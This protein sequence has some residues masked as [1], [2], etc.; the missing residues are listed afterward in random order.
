MPGFF[1]ELKRRN[2]HRA[3]AFYGGAA[4]LLVQIATQVFPFFH[5]ADGVVQA[6]VIGAFVIFPVVL[7]FAWVYEW[8]PQGIKLESEIDRSVSITQ[9]TG[10]AMD[11]WIIVVLS[12]AVLLLL[13][14]QFVLHRF[15]TGSGGD[16]PSIAV[17][18]MA[19][20]TGDP[21]NEYFSDGVSEELINSLSRLQGLKVI[22]RTSSFKFKGSKDDSKTI[23][24]A[25]QV[26]YLLEGSVRRSGEQVRIAV[27]LIKAA[28]G[29]SLWSQSFDREFKDIFAIQT[30]ISATVAKSL[31]VALLGDNAQT[32][33]TPL[34]SAPSNDNAAAYAAL[35]QGNFYRARSTADDFRKAIGFYEE[36]IALDPRYA[37]AY[38]AMAAAASS[39]TASFL[40]SDS[41][42]AEKRVLTEKAQTGVETALRL[43]PDL[44]E[45]HLVNGFLAENVM[46]L[47]KTRA[48]CAQAAELAP[49]N[50]RA[51]MCLGRIQAYL[52]QVQASVDS[53]RRALE[54]EPLGLGSRL[55]L[56]IM[57]TALGRYD[58]AT[59]V[60]RQAIELQ[61]RA[62]IVHR[63]LSIIQTLRGDNAAA[64]ATALQE[65]DPY[66]QTVTLAQSYGAAGLQPQADVQLKKLIDENGS[67]GASQI[68]QTYAARRE[69][70]LAFE[71]LE[72]ARASGDSG[73]LEMRYDPFLM[74]YKS[75]PR[76]LAFGRKIGVISL[77]EVP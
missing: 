41:D 59:A 35:L 5:I 1:S 14:N 66:W 2:V 25:L 37:L 18:P 73:I 46:D 75:D 6:I 17:L 52:G 60:V 51:V 30:E 50:P 7:V 69:P 45:A 12:L 19:N 65:T 40:V 74:R 39:L 8:T 68:A 62:A 28:D 4:W 15:V 21:G 49:S 36:A 63:Q 47:V 56:S 24:E 27:S 43:A 10:K 72:R 9:Q 32:I 77:D 13:L 54:L 31:K 44:A 38:A 57:L 64:I 22:G 3:A 76:Y 29:S 11:R 70:D 34:P 61:P 16:Q 33:N 58:E 67:D 23:A 48:E 53:N 42:A 55:N 71:W 20:S 26:S